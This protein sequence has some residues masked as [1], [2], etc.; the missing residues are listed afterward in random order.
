MNNSEF[1]IRIAVTIA[2]GLHI[3]FEKRLEYLKYV[4]YLKRFSFNRNEDSKVATLLKINFD[5]SKF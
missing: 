1:L 3:T 5:I 2:Y 4:K